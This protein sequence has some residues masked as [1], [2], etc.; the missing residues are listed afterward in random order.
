MLVHLAAYYA[1]HL[2]RIKELRILQTFRK[3][4]EKNIWEEDA[5]LENEQYRV[6]AKVLN[7]SEE[8]VFAVVQRWIF[9]IPL[10]YL[11]K[12]R[13]PF[14]VEFINT[15]HEKKIQTA[16]FSDYPAKEKTRCLGINDCKHFCS[17]DEQINRFKPDPRGLFTIMESLGFSTR[18]CLYI[19]DR[20]D[21]DGECARRA[22]MDYLLLSKNKSSTAPF[23]QN[24]Q[25]LIEHLCQTGKRP[26]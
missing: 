20:D 17:T 1:L 7:V 11:P 24:Y 4:R 16:T 6:T 26:D 10:G 22:G 9:K 2:S 21:R 12:C 8:M 13:Y 5:L 15:L 19:G 25:Q 18:Q 3:L 14:V 23:F